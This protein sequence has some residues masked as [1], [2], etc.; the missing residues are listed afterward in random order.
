MNILPT[1]PFS[2]LTLLFHF[3]RQV[4]QHFLFAIFHCST[5]FQVHLLLPRA[6]FPTSQKLNRVRGIC[7][8]HGSLPVL[9]H[10][11]GNSEVLYCPQWQP[12]HPTARDRWKARIE[13]GACLPRVF[14]KETSG[15]HS[16]IFL[17]ML[18]ISGWKIWC[19]IAIDP[20]FFKWRVLLLRNK[21]WILYKQ[22][23]IC[24]PISYACNSVR[25]NSCFSW[26]IRTIPL[27]WTGH[28]PNL[29]IF[30]TNAHKGRS[31]AV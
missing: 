27:F 17:C 20:V 22:L 19:C 2:S 6:G 25:Q 13:G 15:S 9:S 21:E 28:L 5:V 24:V 14:P 4:M 10:H 16:I 12:P 18:F 31:F 11:Q 1:E 29:K 3:K 30:Q 8:C 26:Q 7:D 23:A